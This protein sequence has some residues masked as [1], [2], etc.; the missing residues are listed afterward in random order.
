MA[1]P[2]TPPALL[3]AGT[4][5]AAANRATTAPAGLPVPGR[6]GDMAAFDGALHHDV[7]DQAEVERIHGAYM[8]ATANGPP[9]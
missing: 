3:D 9:R 7:A 6:P 1:P 2:R 4:C 5:A 8:P